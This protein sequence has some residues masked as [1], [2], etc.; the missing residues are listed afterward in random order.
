VEPFEDIIMFTKKVQREQGRL[1][2][3]TPAS[4]HYLRRSSKK[5]GRSLSSSAVKPLYLSPSRPRK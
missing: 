2:V 4:R 5:S 1:R 3:V